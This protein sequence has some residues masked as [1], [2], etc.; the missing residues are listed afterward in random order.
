MQINAT[1]PTSAPQIAEGFRSGV[2]NSLRSVGAGLQTASDQ[3]GTA[4]DKG[5][6]YPVDTAF[7]FGRVLS[8]ATQNAN[9][10]VHSIAGKIGTVLTYIAAYDNLMVAGMLR[11]PGA[12]ANGVLGLVADK[13]DGG[14]GAAPAQDFSVGWGGLAA[15][16]AQRAAA[17]AA[18]H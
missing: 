4:A 7:T 17:A 11:T 14:K 13:I 2:A 8:A 18:G 1:L 5:Y 6:I 12:T 15:L 16:Q 9:P 3:V 10:K